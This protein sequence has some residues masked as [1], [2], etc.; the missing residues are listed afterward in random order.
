MQAFERQLGNPAGRAEWPPAHPTA[1]ARQEPSAHQEAFAARAQHPGLLFFHAGTFRAELVQAAAQHVRQRLA[2][3]DAPQHAKERLFRVF[4]ELARHLGSRDP[5]AAEPQ[6][7]IAVG[8]LGEHF[9][10]LC[11][12]RLPPERVAPL[13]LQLDAVRR[14]SAQELADLTPAGH[15]FG[16][17]TE[18]APTANGQPQEDVEPGWLQVARNSSAPIEYGFSGSLPDGSAQLHIRAWI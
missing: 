1:P 4:I 10:V 17:L 5:D 15:R 16:T 8:C 9:W 7:R 11:S 14:L 2:E 3:L 18:T 6:G 13:R 12:R